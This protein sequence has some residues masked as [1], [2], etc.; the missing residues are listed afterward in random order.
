MVLGVVRFDGHN[1]AAAQSHPQASGW[2]LRMDGFCVSTDILGHGTAAVSGVSGLAGAIGTVVAQ[3]AGDEARCVCKS[4]RGQREMRCRR[5]D[6]EM[7]SRAQA[8]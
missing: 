4:E 7:A 3:H 8:G 1:V 5:G 2:R 6:R